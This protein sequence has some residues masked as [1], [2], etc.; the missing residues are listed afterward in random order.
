MPLP[1]PLRSNGE[2]CVWKTRTTVW[3]VALY[4]AAC[5]IWL[6]LMQPHFVPPPVYA[7]HI[8]GSL[9][10]KKTLASGETLTQQLKAPGEG[11][12]FI[13]LRPFK[14][15]PTRVRVWNRSRSILLTDQLVTREDGYRAIF[16]PD[17]EAG[18]LLEISV[19]WDAPAPPT[20]GATWLI[21]PGATREQKTLPPASGANRTPLV[22]ATPYTVT[23]T[24]PEVG[25]KNVRFPGLIA[26]E[27]HRVRLD[28][29]R[30]SDGKSLRGVTLRA[31]RR[32]S[33]ELRPPLAS[34]ETATAT[35]NWDPAPAKIALQD[36]EVFAEIS[37][38]DRPAYVL[39]YQRSLVPYLIWWLPAVLIAGLAI[40]RKPLEPAAVF[41]FAFA[42]AA[43]GALAWQ[44]LY[45][46]FFPFTDPD[47]YGQ[48]GAR[49]AA[50]IHGESY[51]GE[52][53][54][55]WTARY[56]HTHIP[57]VPAI[58]G[59]LVACGL[60]LTPTY[61]WIAMASMGCA[62]WVLYR[63]LRTH[64]QI[65]ALPALLTIAL[66][67]T[68]PGV[69]RGSGATSSDALGVLLVVITLA[70]LLRRSYTAKRYDNLALGIL[71]LLNAITR[72]GAP[73]Y[74]I[75]FALAAVLIDAW[76]TRATGWSWKP[77]F[78]TPILLALPSLILLFAVGIPLGWHETFMLSK[79]G[80]VE[81][82][83]DLY[84]WYEWSTCILGSGGLWLLLAPITGVLVWRG[85]KHHLLPSAPA[86]HAFAIGISWSF[87]LALLLGIVAVHI[88][89][90]FVPLTPGIALAGAPALAF[91][92]DKFPRST[93]I[94]VAL[95]G[96]F[97]ILASLW[98]DAITVWIGLPL[99]DGLLFPQFLR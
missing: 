63:M 54:R 39:G 69:L 50:A 58:L 29:V 95:A 66:W 86:L 20:I 17:N 77:F 97:G 11:I 79:E 48:Y 52:T 96:V 7:R 74:A 12:R 4:L 32:E 28:V 92:T 62:A 59:V 80:Y 82:K 2:R 75:Y 49:I 94:A 41:L 16:P 45:S 43:T 90:I 88:L 60:P 40:R 87:F 23:I 70:H 19:S 67:A 6:V 27:D 1:N 76:R 15:G 56:P 18:D 61:L 57:L 26:D 72:P 46:G 98:S 21:P 44:Q 22:A 85:Y 93:I 55:E 68:N 25:T 81:I 84:G 83:G 5:A 71:I 33:G 35:L 51:L 91:I 73:V 47:R 13:Q 31:G 89:R 8:E 53:F 3:F 14:G 24:A 65:A 9:G 38:P 36:G 78:L 42:A 34:G 64:V 37:G 99:W 10:D 30:D